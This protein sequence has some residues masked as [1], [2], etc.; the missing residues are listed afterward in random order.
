MLLDQKQPSHYQL[1]QKKT[2]LILKKIPEIIDDYKE[3]YIRNNEWV[4]GPC[5]KEWLIKYHRFFDV[6]YQDAAHAWKPAVILIVHTNGFGNIK[7][8]FSIRT[9]KCC[10]YDWNDIGKKDTKH[11]EYYEKSN[12][13]LRKYIK[14][15]IFNK[16]LTFDETIQFLD[17]ELEN[18]FNFD[19][20]ESK[21]NEEAGTGNNITYRAGKL[22]DYTQIRKIAN[23][24]KGEF[25]FIKRVAIEESI[26]KKQLI[27]AEID[28]VV[29]GF[30]HFYRRKDGGKYC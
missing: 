12:E 23:Q 15:E 3:M 26:Q 18:D 2:I 27:V 19:P 7:L 9:K 8:G 22:K 6:T 24:Y 17:L 28:H 14:K 20:I 25:G 13:F 21:L 29:V 1:E 16:G 4:G 30:I 10:S 5:N 11:P